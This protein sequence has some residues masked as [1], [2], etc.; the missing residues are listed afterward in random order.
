MQMQVTS[1]AP[2]NIYSDLVT[3][4]EVMGIKPTKDQLRL[5]VRALEPFN[6]HVRKA[7]IDAVAM[8]LSKR[9]LPADFA[10]AAKQI[11]GVDT[12][13]L[14]R[15]GVVQFNK[16]LEIGS[17]TRCVLCDDW[18]VV[19]SVN[20]AFGSLSM[21]FNS[22][23]EKVWTQKRFAEAYASVD[24]FLENTVMKEYLLES[25]LQS[26]HGG[27]RQLVFLG[28]Y[29]NCMQLFAQLPNKQEFIVPCAP[30]L[31]SQALP[32]NVQEDIS[33][34]QIAEN[35]ARINE[36]LSSF[37]SRGLQGENQRTA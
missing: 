23:E 25:N 30:Q 7:A 36:I 3:T 26:V 29:N 27:Y 12:E 14:K 22:T 35:K 31:P 6:D 9:P 8:T 28:D 17:D 11:C 10:N 13:S 32:N 24:F 2:C 5:Y 33:P 20:K 21:F 1:Q 19:Y 16:L 15:R 4:L 34:E 37:I 18:R